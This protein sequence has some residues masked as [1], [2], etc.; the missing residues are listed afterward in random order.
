M[1]QMPI[2]LK[3]MYQL[4]DETISRL[5]FG[6]KAKECWE[7]HYNYQFLAVTWRRCLENFLAAIETHIK[8]IEN[9]EQAKQ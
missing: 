5:A 1:K 7:N 4:R 8:H 3:E 2:T 9:M 6:Y